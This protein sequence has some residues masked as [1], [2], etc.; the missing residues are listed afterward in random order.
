MTR[1][2]WTG[3]L[4]VVA[5]LVVANLL[6]HR[7]PAGA[8]LPAAVVVSALLLALARADGLSWSDVGLGRESVASGLRWSALLLAAV[9]IGYAALVLSPWAVDVLRDD[10]YT[11]QTAGALLWTVLVRIPLATVLLEELAF[12]G[13]LLAVLARRWG[14][15]PAVV[16][17]SLLF[18]VWHVLPAAAAGSNDALAGTPPPALVAGV[19]LGTALAGA[20]LCWLRLRSGSLLPP[21]VLHWAVNA[22]GV[23]AVWVSAR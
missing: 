7:G 12:R 1:R 10:R 14:T 15:R 8:W 22:L 23:V 17:S 16:A 3:P 5:V 18:G 13:V 20:V 11:D 19:V 6:Q 21:L 2:R 4:A 9:A